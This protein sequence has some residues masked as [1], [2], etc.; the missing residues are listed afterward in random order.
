MQ[1]DGGSKEE[2]GTPIGSDLDLTKPKISLPVTQSHMMLT[3]AIIPRTYR[4]FH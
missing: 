3:M 2:A 1:V 4:K